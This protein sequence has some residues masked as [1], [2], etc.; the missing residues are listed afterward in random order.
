MSLDGRHTV[1]SLE[2]PVLSAVS[3]ESKAVKMEDTGIFA[4]LCVDYLGR[5]DWFQC[6]WQLAFSRGWG[7]GLLGR[8]WAAN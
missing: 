7:R 2:Y 4:Y 1:Q 5:R 3:L 8:G 6:S